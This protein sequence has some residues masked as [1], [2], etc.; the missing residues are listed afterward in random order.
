M[1][2]LNLLIV[3]IFCILVLPYLFSEDNQRK[4]SIKNLTQTHVVTNVVDLTFNEKKIIA[5]VNG[6]TQ[7]EY[8]LTGET[9]SI[10]KEFGEMGLVIT[11]KN[12]LA[13]SSNATEFI[14]QPLFGDTGI[15]Y[16]IAN[17]ILFVVTNKKIY[18]YTVSTSDWKKIDLTGE[19]VQSHAAY[20]K[21]GTLITNKRIISYSENL[22][23]FHFY[24]IDAFTPIYSY[25]VLENKIVYDSL[26]KTIIY[27]PATGDYSV[28]NFN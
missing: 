19:I 26:Q 22:Q 15:T 23:E 25:T 12:L 3:S 21:T 6:S 18:V 20:N 13:I 8:K 7:L 17:S 16:T 28:V 14:R 24:S 9:I 2:R 1:N 27:R 4:G 10:I 5:L 11:N